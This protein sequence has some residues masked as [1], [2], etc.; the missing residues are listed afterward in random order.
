MRHASRPGHADFTYDAKSGV[1]AWQGG[2]RASARETVGRVAAGA[3]AEQVLAQRFGALRIV[4]WVERVHDIDARAHIEPASVTRDIVDAHPTRCPH[5]ESARAMEAAILDAKKRGDSLG[6]YLRLYV[7][8]VP[9]GLGEPVFDKLDA[10]LAQ[11]FMSLPACKGVEMGSGF[12]GPATSGLEHNDIFEW[13]TSG[14]GAPP[15]M[16]TRSNRSG[17]VQGGISNGMPLDVRLEI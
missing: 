7:E 11:A 10:L 8:G 2:G 16:S 1:R 9:P 5:P 14:S 17:G 3:V 12:W 4:A 6:G 15:E 13:Q